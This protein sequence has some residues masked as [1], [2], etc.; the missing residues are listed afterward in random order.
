MYTDWG[1]FPSLY[2][3]WHHTGETGMDETSKKKKKKKGPTLK[4]NPAPLLFEKKHGCVAPLPRCDPDEIP[5]LC[6]N[7][8][9]VSD[10]SVKLSKL[11]RNIQF[12][13]AD[14][15]L[16]EISETHDFPSLQRCCNGLTFDIFTTPRYDMVARH[17]HVAM[18]F[19]PP[20]HRY[21]SPYII[22]WGCKCQVCPEGQTEK[23]SSH[24]AAS[25]IPQGQLSD[26][27]GCTCQ[28]ET[29]SFRILFKLLAM[30]SVQVRRINAIHS[31]DLDQGFWP[32]FNQQES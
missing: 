31:W 16:T 4:S 28:L 30:A 23:G 20:W 6:W 9:K 18:W 3:G 19:S 22:M 5:H 21:L 32:I 11:Y 29:V 2:R 1:K 25:Q 15:Q 8:P 10:S 14:L 24:N 26:I 17:R 7:L 13:S 27:T 12:Y